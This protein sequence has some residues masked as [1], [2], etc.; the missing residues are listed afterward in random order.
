MEFK[1]TCKLCDRKFANGKSMGG[2][3]RSHF[4]KLSVQLNPSSPHPSKSLDVPDTSEIV[5]VPKTIMTPPH[6]NYARGFLNLESG[7]AYGSRSHFA[8][9]TSVFSAAMEVP[10]RKRS[11]RIHPQ[12][13]GMESAQ[14]NTPQV[15][16]KDDHGYFSSPYE[17]ITVKDAALCLMMLS[18]KK[19]PEVVPHKK[20]TVNSDSGDSPNDNNSFCTGDD[21]DDD[22]YTDSMDLKVS[23]HRCKI[24]KK[25]FKSYQALGGHMRNH[26]RPVTIPTLAVE[27]KEFPCNICLK[28]FSSGQALGGHKKVHL[29]TAK[30]PLENP[31]H[32]DKLPIAEV[33]SHSESRSAYV[34]TFGNDET[35]YD[36]DSYYDGAK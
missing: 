10:A 18:N 8:S 24:C 6:V 32:N 16:P 7:Y 31:L 28:V 4:V 25:M 2:H 22:D 26:K 30:K 11:K 14:L 3:M 13:K 29:S 27:K 5:N 1:H 19:C 23:G 33:Y 21:A 15:N 9:S 20:V 36:S 34:Y 12:L 35:N 17:L